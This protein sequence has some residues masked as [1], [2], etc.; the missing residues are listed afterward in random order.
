MGKFM[1]EH[2]HVSRALSWPVAV[3]SVVG[4]HARE[5]LKPIFM[6]KQHDITNAGVTFWAFISRSAS[7]TLVQ[8]LGA[9]NKGAPVLFIASATAGGAVP[10]V[11]SDR[12]REFSID[13]SVWQPLPKKIGPVTG[14][15]SRSGTAL[16]LGRLDLAAQDCVID[17]WAYANFEDTASP[18]K[19]ARGASTLC[20]QQGNTGRH[21]DA[22]RSHLR[23]VLA[24]GWVYEPYAAWLR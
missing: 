24:I 12:A 11:S 23:T 2:D 6:R 7:P 4:S 5:D 3:I 16:V 20:A 14:S 21:P 1:M 8:R 17:L 22:M 19:I 18:V 9:R 10:T 15:L 13:R